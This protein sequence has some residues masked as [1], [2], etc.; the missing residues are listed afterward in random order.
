M[1]LILAPHDHLHIKQKNASVTRT[2]PRTG[3]P[4]PAGHAGC[5]G[6]VC[7]GKIGHVN[8]L[9]LAGVEVGYK[10]GLPALLHRHL[11]R[12]S[13]GWQ[14]AEQCGPSLEGIRY[15]HSSKNG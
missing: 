2:G 5:G 13:T 11:P 8:G 9:K 6:P 14:V 4:D 15:V 3:L 10:Q 1:L 7:L 12:E